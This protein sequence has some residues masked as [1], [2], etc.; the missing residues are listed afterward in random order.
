[1]FCVLMIGNELQSTVPVKRKSKQ[2]ES[3]SDQAWFWVIKS[4][5]ST[6]GKVPENATGES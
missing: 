3:K 4:V 2:K 5:Q 6:T 1:M